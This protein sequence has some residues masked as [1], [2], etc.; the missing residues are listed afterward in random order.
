M[1]ARRAILI[2]LPKDKCDIN[3]IRRLI[4]LTNLAYRDYE[5]LVPDMF[6][7]VQYQ[8]YGSFKN[9]KGSLVFGTTP[10]RW[11]AETW[12]PLKA[13]R[14]YGDGSRK[15][16]KGAPVV[17]DFRRSVTRLRQVCKNESRYVV[18]LPMPKW[19]IDRIKEGGDV[20]FAMIGLKDDKPYLALVAERVVEPYVPSGYRL[21]VDV[22]AWSNGVAYGIIN[23]NNRIAEYSPLRPNLRLIDTWYHKAEKLSKE[24][25]K[26][27]RLGLGSTLEAER[28]KR[29]IDMLG[30]KIYAY[31]RDFTQKR[32]HE[33]AI[34][35]LR[36]RAEVLIDDMIE[37]SR[38]ELLEEKIPS[39]LRKLYIMYT[40]RFVRLLITQLQWYGVPYEF[41]R[42][43][44]TICPVCQHELTQL[45][46]RIMVCSNCGFKAPRD[47]VPIHWAIRTINPSFAGFYQSPLKEVT[48][49]IPRKSVY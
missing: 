43:P 30:R 42:L 11:F 7:Y 5:V 47:K 40:R 26:L 15:G 3:Y 46:G 25:G 4:A 13:L 28:L 38:R 45:P 18:E 2:E 44:S 23:P 17:L 1:T 36:L 34:K 24:L 12:V 20:R 19:V 21:V 49:K 16:D 10:K 9:F 22:N 39:G 37:E 48:F 31:L 41:K 35:A 27:K 8:L 32:A 33:L 14:V 6:K 29:E